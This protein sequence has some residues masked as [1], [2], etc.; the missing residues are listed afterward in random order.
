[1]ETLI[2]VLFQDAF[3]SFFGI[4]LEFFS[5]IFAGALGASG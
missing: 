1:M 4:I 5:S 3:L 2:L